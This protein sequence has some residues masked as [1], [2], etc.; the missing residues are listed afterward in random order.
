LATALDLCESAL[1]E[2]G[3]LAASETAPA[4]EANDALAQLNRFIDVLATE[5]GSIFYRT[6]TLATLTANQASFTVGTGGNINIPRPVFIHHV[7]YVDTTPSPDVEIPLGDGLTED[8]YAGLVVKALTSTRPSR[9][10]YS[11]TYPLGTLYPWPIP[12]DSGLQWAVYHSSAVSQFAALGD[13]VSLPPAYEE[14][15]VKNLAVLLAP[16]FEKQPSPLTLKAAVESLSNIRRANTRRSEMSF[17][18]ASLISG[19]G[20]F[21]DIRTDTYR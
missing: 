16:Q 14:M 6:R 2:I 13:T 11:P 4:G 8:E 3:A 5:P 7:N 1:K 17:E 15:L 9:W 12:S 10:Y 19:G 21:Y 18:A 20:G